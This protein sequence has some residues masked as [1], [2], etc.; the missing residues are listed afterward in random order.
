[1]VF[2]SQFFYGIKK[3]DSYT[4]YMQETMNNH[5]NNNK[6]KEGKAEEKIALWA[7]FIP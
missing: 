5:I 2:F 6:A 1:M 4:F 7:L 3:I